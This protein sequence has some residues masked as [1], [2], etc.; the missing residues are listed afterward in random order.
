MKKIHL[1]KETLRVLT[2]DEA[3]AVGGATVRD[4][5]NPTE[6]RPATGCGT[7]TGTGTTTGTTTGVTGN[8][9]TPTS[10]QATCPTPTTPAAGCPGTGP[11]TTTTVETVRRCPP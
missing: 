9:P 10:P 1:S 2:A 11:G 7:G 4:G 3:R 8:C 6:T 5:C